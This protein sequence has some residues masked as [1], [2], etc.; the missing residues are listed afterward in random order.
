VAK[1]LKISLETGRVDLEG[2][3]AEGASDEEKNER[4]LA[5]VDELKAEMAEIEPLVGDKPRDAIM[6]AWVVRTYLDAHPVRWIR[7]YALRAKWNDV[8]KMVDDV[9][10]RAASSL[11]E[12][13]GQRIWEDLPYVREGLGLLFAKLRS[14]GEVQRLILSPLGK[15]AFAKIR[16]QREGP[17]D[18]TRVA[19]EIEEVVRA[20][21]HMDKEANAWGDANIPALLS[22][23]PPAVIPP[24]KA[25][26]MAP[27]AGLLVLGLVGVGAGVVLGPPAPAALGALGVG[28]L[29]ALVGVALLAG[30]AK[31]KAALP[32]EFMELSAKFRER[33]YLIICL[34]GLYQMTSRLTRATDAFDSF[35]KE[36]GGVN[37]WKRVKMDEKDVTRLF[38]AGAAE[39]HPKET[40]ETWL[41]DQVT[42]TYRLDSQSLAAQADIDAEAWDAIMRAYKLSSDEM[43]GDGK[44]LDVVADLLFVGRGEDRKAERKRVFGDVYK[45]WDKAERDRATR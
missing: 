14:Q 1:T 34:R 24:E 42:K 31:R 8:A 21:V 37:R 32:K 26:S 20:G 23:Q 22:G 4:T 40:I 39:W 19:R 5:L 45:A 11:P 25:V 3:P 17:D 2:A 6:R 33:L 28:A 35:V 44:L 30:A 12:G 9:R 16:Y 10:E 36:K 38:A 15:L 7:N 29:L 13:E 41:S 18:L 43:S 27:G